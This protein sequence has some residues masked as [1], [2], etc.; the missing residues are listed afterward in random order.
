[1]ERRGDEDGDGDG[2]RLRWAMSLA[3]WINRVVVGVMRGRRGP[4]G[5][6][7]AGEMAGGGWEQAGLGPLA[8]AHSVEEEGEPNTTCLLALPS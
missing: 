5:K 3:G 6:E 7:E 2:G 4:A 8:A 1:M